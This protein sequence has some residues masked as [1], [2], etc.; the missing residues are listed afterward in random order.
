MLLSTAPTKLV[1]AFANGGSKNTIPQTTGTPGAASYTVGF[2]PET[3]EAVSSGGIPPSGLDFNGIYNEGSSVIERWVGAGGG[4]PFDGTFATAVGGYPKG[5]RVLNAAGTGY[6]RSIIDN[7]S[8]NP[9]TGGA[10]WVPDSMRA[11]AS[12]YASAQQTLVSGNTK[13]LWDTVEQ[14]SF[15]LWDATDKRFTALW[16]GFYRLSGS[17]YLPAPDGQNL[18]TMVYKNGAFAKLCT[19]FPQVSSVALS[20][21]FDAVVLCAVGDYLEAFL[22]VSSTNVLA[23]QSGSNEAYV[24]GQIEYMGN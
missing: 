12:V 18:G 3:M 1:T 8:N 22:A 21:P 14:D 13:I 7:N 4:W 6:W 9:D 2:P 19:Q 24:F 16:A 15:G 5:A 11:A 23:G 10:G 17:V 20:Y